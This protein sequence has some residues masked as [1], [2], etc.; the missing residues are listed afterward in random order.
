MNGFVRTSMKSK[1]VKPEMVRMPRLNKAAKVA[2]EG[3]QGVE[4]ERRIH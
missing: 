2:N 3:D 4:I 1:V